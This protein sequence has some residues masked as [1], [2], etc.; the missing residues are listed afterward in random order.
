MWHADASVLK[1]P[2]GIPDEKLLDKV[3]KNEIDISFVVTHRLPLEE[4]P[5]AY[6]TFRDKKDNCIRLVLKPW[7]S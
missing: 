3:L 6:R 5:V 4:G 2:D 7:A 1:V